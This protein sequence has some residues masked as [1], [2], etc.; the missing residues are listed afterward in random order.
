MRGHNQRFMNGVALYL[1]QIVLHCRNPDTAGAP[2]NP[3][4]N[5]ANIGS[6]D[7]VPLAAGVDIQEF[8]AHPRT[9]RWGT[10]RPIAAYW[11]NYRPGH[12]FSIQLGAAAQ[13][14]FTPM[15]DGCYIGIT[16]GVN[17]TVCHLAGDFANIRRNGA[18]ATAIAQLGAPIA[19]G[20]DSSVMDAPCAIFVGARIA[21]T[22]RFFVQGRNYGIGNQ[23]LALQ[24][25]FN[26][27]G[28]VVEDVAAP[29]VQA[30]AF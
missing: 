11:L 10:Q 7:L 8:V 9:H 29:A 20:F 1:G 15:V 24:A 23:A 6:F 5:G 30:L 19:M 3:A 16:A 14:M 18:R 21:G 26:G 27:R 28:N 12:F 4:V 13:Y 2:F 25:V 22:W 17:P